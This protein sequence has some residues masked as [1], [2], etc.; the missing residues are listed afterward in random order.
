MYMYVLGP[1]SRQR[2]HIESYLSKSL[3]CLHTNIEHHINQNFL[4][5][6]FFIN[7]LLKQNTIDFPLI[8]QGS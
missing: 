1:F 7:V 3:W 2:Y 8:T 5:E 6:R 4:M